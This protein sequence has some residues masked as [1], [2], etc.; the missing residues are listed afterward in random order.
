MADHLYTMAEACATLK[1]S[2][3]WLQDFLKPH[4]FYKL[5]GKRKRFT[6]AHFDAIVEALPC[7]S[8]SRD[9]R[10]ANTGTSEGLFVDGKF[11]KAPLSPYG[12][13]LT[14]SAIAIA[15]RPKSSAA[16][17]MADKRKPPHRK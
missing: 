12:E 1:V 2:R 5:V 14:P 15:S 10:K 16:T 4:P 11:I 6:P 3:S 7:P 17:S 13:R 8:D 9:E